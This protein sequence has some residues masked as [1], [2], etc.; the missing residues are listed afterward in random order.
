MGAAAV[1]ALGL[2]LLAIGLHQ[3]SPGPATQ[4]VTGVGIGSALGDAGIA[5]LSGRRLRCEPTTREPFASRCTVT[6]AG[7]TLELLAARNP[8][9][10]PNQ[11]GGVCAASYAG[12]AWPCRIGSRHLHVH[13]FAYLDDPLGLAAAQIAA[14]R[15]AHPFEN[16]PEQPY[17]LGIAALTAL[18]T[19]VGAS[20]WFA[21]GGRG[22]VRAT[23]AGAFCGLGAFVGAFVMVVTMTSGFWD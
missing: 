1:Y 20:I 23:A 2:L 11:F 18:A 3:S 21:G 17:L 22:R 9:G 14:V 13:W 19:V 10:H 6:V 15:W 4:E 8:P 12:R 7:A 5:Y 16:A